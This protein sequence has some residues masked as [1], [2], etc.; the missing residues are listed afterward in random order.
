MPARI[1]SDEF[2]AGIVAMLAL[3]DQRHFVMSD[4]ELDG[5]FQKAFETLV[6]SQAEYG[7]QPSFSF[8]VDPYHGDSVCLRETLTAAREKELVTFNNP[9]LRTFDVKL[10]DARAERYLDRNPM[11]RRF[12]EQVV[13]Q[14]FS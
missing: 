1:T 10:S 7:I 8:Y 13:E 4:T 14:Q 9:T 11:P 5:R 12:F 6:D 3:R 2:V